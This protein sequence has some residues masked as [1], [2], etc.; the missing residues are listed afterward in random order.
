M[1]RRTLSGPPAHT[2]ADIK[3][4]PGPSNREAAACPSHS[5]GKSARTAPEK[6]S[7]SVGRKKHSAFR[8]VAHRVLPVLSLPDAAF[9][10]ADGDW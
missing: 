8:R 5:L 1:V 10:V 9:G 3:I 4:E 2:Y 7:A 6:P